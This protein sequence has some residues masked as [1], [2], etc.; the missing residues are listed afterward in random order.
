[1][2]V[3]HDRYAS[4]T[5]TGDAIGFRAGRISC[6]TTCSARSAGYVGRLGEGQTLPHDFGQVAGFLEGANLPAGAG[7]LLGELV[8]VLEVA[9]AAQFLAAIGE[10]VNERVQ[11][12]AVPARTGTWWD[13]RGWPPSR[14]GRPATCSG[15][16]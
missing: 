7:R 2:K 8:K 13:R 14:S 5:V 12:P 10:P 6:P 4:M 3:R 16:P 9:G 11:G 15:G 1:M